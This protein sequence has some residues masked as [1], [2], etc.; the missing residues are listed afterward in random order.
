M[1]ARA[2]SARYRIPARRRVRRAGYQ[3][4]FRAGLAGAAYSLKPEPTDPRESAVQLHWPLEPGAN[5]G[6]CRLQR[7]AQSLLR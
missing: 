5:F 2:H 4:N 7:E 1:Q 6:R 3:E